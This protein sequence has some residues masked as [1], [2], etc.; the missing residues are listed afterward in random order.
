V[1]VVFDSAGK[2]SIIALQAEDYGQ[3]ALV[4]AAI[5]AILQHLRRSGFAREFCG[6]DDDSSAA[7]C[8]H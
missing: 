3:E 1:T 2:Q 8:K 4:D 6:A 5:D 7:D